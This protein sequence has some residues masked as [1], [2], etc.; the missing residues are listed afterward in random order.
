MKND[1]ILNLINKKK[2]D[3]QSTVK[4]PKKLNTGA[5][6]L[7]KRNKDKILDLT[8][9][10]LRNF[11]QSNVERFQSISVLKFLI[12]ACGNDLSSKTEK[13][14][15]SLYKNADHEDE[16]VKSIVKEISTSI[17]IVFDLDVVIPIITRNLLDNDLKNNNQ[18][19]GNRMFVLANL[20]SKAVSINFDNINMIINTLKELDIY[21][22]VNEQVGKSIFVHSFE[23]YSGIINSLYSKGSDNILN[24]IQ[25]IHSELFY[26]LLLLYSLP[27]L[28][29]ISRNEVPAVLQKM[30]E[31]CGFK[32]IIGLYSLE[33]SF[34][35][36]KFKSSH[37]L[38]RRNT[39]DRYAFDTFVKYAG[40]SLNT[41][42]GENWIKVLE[43]ISNCTEAEKDIEMRMDMIVLMDKLFED[44]NGNKDSTISYFSEF[45]IEQILLPAC[46][47]RAQR[48][49]Y[50]IR[51]AALV[52]LIKLYKFNL[53][54]KECS[55]KYFTNYISMLKSSMEDDW[56]CELR[57]LSIQ[58]V[59]ILLVTNNNNNFSNCFLGESELRELY[60]IM[61]KRLDD[62]QDENRKVICK[63]FEHFFILVRDRLK[64]SAS[65]IEYIFQTSC[66]HL[67]DSKREIR[68][69]VYKF[70]EI[71]FS[72]GDERYIN[73]LRRIV[74]E[75]Y[76]KFQNKDFIDK[77]K[78]R[79]N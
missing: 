44:A 45:I 12:E 69:S 48:P 54:E 74:D 11:S 47:W 41:G 7:I 57:N 63:A 40:E 76:L 21:V 6:Y 2:Q 77:L 19:L 36:D 64:I 22:N 62:S 43:I 32:D 3:K 8:I 1:L 58:L 13:I 65:A 31:I 33:L 16:Q 26:Q 38:W 4:A 52:C 18:A 37:K 49:N 68:E 39:A 23:I 24:L 72:I 28:P 25:N 30:A 27:I 70:L 10:D 78:E 59:T 17:G 50:N 53:I 9:E 29:Q 73:S 42:S 34:L 79:L 35:L 51:K 15:L 46:M 20:L 71:L 56:D 61:L 5:Q 67:D 55:L 75:E 60:P 66:I 14:L